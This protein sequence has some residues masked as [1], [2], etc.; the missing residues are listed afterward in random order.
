MKVL[1]FNGSPHKEGCTY[2]ALCEI[3][4]VLQENGID[5][6]IVQIG[7]VPYQ[8]CMACRGCHGTGKCVF[9]EKDGLNELID[10][11]AEADG[12]IFGSPV[13]YASANA[14]LIGFMDRLFFAAS[15]KLSHKPAAAIASARRAGTTVTVDELNKYFTINQMPIVSSSYW[16]VIHGSKAEDAQQDLEGLQTM[17][18]LG[19]NMAWMLKCIEAGRNAGIS[20]PETEHGFVTNFIR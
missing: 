14:T 15:G 11:C 2:T 17:R 9:G 4:A 10:R 16:N 8:G 6:E 12:F 5:A 3:S 13:Y 18:N 7:S 1:L 19:R 20:V